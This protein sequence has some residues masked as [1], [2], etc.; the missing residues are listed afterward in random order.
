MPLFRLGPIRERVQ[1]SSVVAA[2]EGPD[3][4][5]DDDRERRIG[6]AILLGL[7]VFVLVALAGSYFQHPT[8]ELSSIR[9]NIASTTR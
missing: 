6:I 5:Q 9:G 4:I 7:A 2:M 1:P 3:M 8:S